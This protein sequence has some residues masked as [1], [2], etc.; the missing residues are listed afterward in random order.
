[1]IGCGSLIAAVSSAGM[2]HPSG[3]RV[4]SAVGH[5]AAISGSK[6][7]ALRGPQRAG[8]KGRAHGPN[9]AVARTLASRREDASAGEAEAI[10]ARAYILVET[11]DQRY[12]SPDRQ[13]QCRRTESLRASAT[14][15]L[16]GPDRFATASA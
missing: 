2:W 1:M 3:V 5:A 4:L 9:G 11:A 15:A 6:A 14:R 8:V 7:R 12:G 10:A 16:P 13:M